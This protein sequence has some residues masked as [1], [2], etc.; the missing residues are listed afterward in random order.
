MA[1]GTSGR[2]LQIQRS[3][4]LR[5]C[6]SKSLSSTLRRNRPVKPFAPV[7]RPLPVSATGSLSG[8]VGAFEVG[9]QRH[10]PHHV[11]HPMDHGL[12]HVTDT[13]LH[14]GRDEM[15]QYGAADY[16]ESGD[17]VELDQGKQH[18]CSTDQVSKDVHKSSATPTP[19]GNA[20]ADADA[21]TPDTQ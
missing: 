13:G 17:D 9:S 8:D 6:T 15:M 5:P 19:A 20:S 11:E 3:L 14:P 1:Y 4:Y 16:G 21:Q 18:H 2:L 10:I 12:D 7:S